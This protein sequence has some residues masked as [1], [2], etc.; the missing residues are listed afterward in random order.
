MFSRERRSR[1]NS[2][3]PVR[4]RSYKFKMLSLAFLPEDIINGNIR[5]YLK[6]DHYVALLS[7]CKYLRKTYFFK[8]VKVRLNCYD[9]MSFILYDNYYNRIL[10]KIYKK[11]T[12]KYLCLNLS[13]LN[14]NSNKRLTMRNLSNIKEN[15]HLIGNLNTLNIRNLYNKYFFIND[16]LKLLNVQT[17]LLTCNSSNKKELIDNLD[18]LHNQRNIKTI[19]IEE[20]RES[21]YQDYSEILICEKNCINQFIGKSYNDYNKS[22]TFNYISYKTYLT[23]GHKNL[24]S[25]KHKLHI[26]DDY[27]EYDDYLDYSYGRRND[28]YYDDPYGYESDDTKDTEDTEER[29]E[30][31]KEQYRYERYR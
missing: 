13:Y 9:S 14:N 5:L 19:I 16:L 3:L 30:R 10:N 27:D 11:N 26:E 18:C 25:L 6:F 17:L 1:E 31:Y 29:Y 23:T 15:F 24:D 20:F 12:C 8:L 28:H 21:Y 7:C 2:S 4:K 22:E